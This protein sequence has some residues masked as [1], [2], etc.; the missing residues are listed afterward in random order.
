MYQWQRQEIENYIPIP[1]TLMNCINA[2][3]H[4][5]FSHAH[6]E[7]LERILKENIPPVAYKNSADNFW[8][9][10]NISDFL[11]KIFAQFLDETNQS[12]N[13]MDKS[14]FYL[15]VEHIDNDQ[16]DGEL[17]KTLDGIFAHLANVADA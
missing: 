17:E 16:L 1:S 14:K 5:L 7:K 9:E 4:D 8:V 13:T 3:S 15:L 11:S 10:T 6:P 2:Q 12:R